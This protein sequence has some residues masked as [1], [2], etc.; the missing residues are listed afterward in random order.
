MAVY[1]QEVQVSL[2]KITYFKVWMAQEDD[3]MTQPFPAESSQSVNDEWI[4]S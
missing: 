1:F 2:I 4:Q 3:M